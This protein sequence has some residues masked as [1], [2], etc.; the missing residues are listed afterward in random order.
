MNKYTGHKIRYRYY[1]VTDKYTSVELGMTFY[2]ITNSKDNTHINEW[3][4][5]E[6]DIFSL[7]HIKSEFRFYRIETGDHFNSYE[8]LN[9]KMG[10]RRTENYEKYK[11]YYME[12]TYSGELKSLCKLAYDN[13]KFAYNCAFELCE[14]GITFPFFWG[15]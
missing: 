10:K 7:K 11:K 14:G 4:K 1:Y 15:I 6:L 13:F 8:I 3:I 5:L 9:I 2:D 12:K